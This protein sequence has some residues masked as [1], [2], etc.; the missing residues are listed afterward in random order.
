MNKKQIAITL[1]IVCLILTIAISVQLK[2]IRNA[3]S[4]VSQSLV[5]N[6]LRDDVLKWKEKYDNAYN[7]LQTSEKA[8]ELVRQNATQDNDASQQKEQELKRNKI[9]LGLTD[10][11]G[12]GV[13][14]T[15]KDNPNISTETLG[16]ADDISLYLIHDIDLRAIINELENAGA[17]AISINDQRIVI[18]SAITCE[19]NVIKINGEKIGSPFTIKAIGSPELLYNINRPGGYMARL[20]ETGAIGEVKKV[21]SVT[22]RK[23]TGVISS[24]VMKYAN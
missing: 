13:V 6:G 18:N 4:V 15:L 19:G 16:P 22:I 5:D 1:G 21:N 2:T 23:F 7:D 20:N 14:V 17:E 11:T 9:L 24:K 12:S 10:V 8:L 3:N